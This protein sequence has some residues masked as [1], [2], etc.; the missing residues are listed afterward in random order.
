MLLRLAG[1]LI[2][3]RAQ[4]RRGP[5][6]T[7]MPPPPAVAAFADPA[8]YVRASAYTL[9][10]SRFGSVTAIFDTLILGLALFSGFLPWLYARVAGWGT[11]DAA[12]SG[13][14]F[15]LLAFV[16]LAVPSM[17]FEWWEQFRIEARAGFN[18]TTLVLWLADRAKGLALTLA[19][20]FPLLWAL[21]ALV[22]RAGPSWWIW[23]FVFS[24]LASSWRRFSFI[25]G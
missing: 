11:P 10:K 21:L 22:H 1:E 2:L 8:T 5:A 15:I 18:R 14:L 4:S 25:R 7:R 23:G 6:R 24:S 12:W 20:G 17:P 3:V 13:A 16:I 9:E 19:I